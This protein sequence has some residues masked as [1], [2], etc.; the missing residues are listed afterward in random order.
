MSYFNPM[1]SRS[2]V[3]G[4]TA[5]LVAALAASGCGGSG[6][7]TKLS[8]K[9]TYKGEPVPGAIT[10]ETTVNG[11]PS[12]YPA[13]I[14]A[15]GKFETVGVPKGT[16]QV[17]ITPVPSSTTV[18]PGGSLP[19]GAAGSAPKHVDI[20]AKYLK[21]ETSGLTWEVTGSSQTKDF[22]LTD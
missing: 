11:T 15:D 6:S 1:N 13:A 9:V 4:L 5:C 16:Y 12:K 3:A 22:D 19:P 21:P 7:A 10:L 8:G 17:G 2:L 14:S 18:T 20:P